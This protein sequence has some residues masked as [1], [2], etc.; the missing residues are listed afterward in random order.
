[1]KRS[2]KPTIECLESKKLLATMTISAASIH[3]VP[4]VA[5]NRTFVVNLAK[6]QPTKTTGTVNHSIS[7]VLRSGISGLRVIQNGRNVGAVYMGVGSGS[8]TMSLRG[9]PSQPTATTQH[10]TVWTT[11]L[12]T[13]PTTNAAQ[14]TTP[15]HSTVWSTRLTTQPATNAAKDTTTT[16]PSGPTYTFHIG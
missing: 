4:N 11:R 13:Q 6:I 7:T 15:Q 1:M 12:T 14:D 10:S 8:A 5:A 3:M 16:P 9:L 2:R